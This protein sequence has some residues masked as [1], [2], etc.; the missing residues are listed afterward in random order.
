M[1]LEDVAL[2]LPSDISFVSQKKV[3]KTLQSQP[4]LTGKCH[5]KKDK[6]IAE[7]ITDH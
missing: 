1:P 2:F 3:I 6:D 7:P 4:L 5:R